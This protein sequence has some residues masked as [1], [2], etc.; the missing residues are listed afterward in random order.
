MIP[1]SQR[2]RHPTS[3]GRPARVRFQS[4]K[5][6][7][8]QASANVYRH[9]KQKLLTSNSAA[10]EERVHHAA[11]ELSSSSNKQ[12]D[13]ESSA[14]RRPTE[15][16]D[17]EAAG[18]ELS[19][20][21]DAV[22]SDLCETTGGTSKRFQSSAFAD[23]L[24]IV[25]DRNPSEIFVKFHRQV[26]PLVRSLPEL[27]H[28]ASQVVDLILSSLLT[29]HC[30]TREEEAA[31]A[32][33]V[34]DVQKQDSNEPMA[35]VP[36]PGI[37]YYS[38]NLATN[39]LLHL[40]AVFARDVR[41]EIHPYLHTRILPRLVTDL[42]R[43]PPIPVP[44]SLPLETVETVF[45]T[46]AYVFKYDATPLLAEVKGSNGDGTASSSSKDSSLPCLELLRQYYGGTLA[47]RNPLVRRLAGETFA[48]VIRR[49]PTDKAQSKH[50]K[51][52]VRS[53]MSVA[54]QGEEGQQVQRQK[55]PVPEFSTSIVP[56]S[57]RLQ[58][59]AADG[60]AGLLWEVARGV[61]G[62]FHSRG[63]NV[64]LSSLLDCMQSASRRDRA[65]LWVVAE[66]T[67]GFLHRALPHLD[68]APAS[69]LM[70]SLVDSTLTMANSIESMSGD[71]ERDDSLT[72]LVQA[73]HQGA[74]FRRGFVLQT[75]PQLQ[76]HF[77][78]LLNTVLA[79]ELFSRLSSACQLALIKLI[80]CVWGAVPESQ[81]FADS[82]C[83]HLRRLLKL[84]NN[85]NEDALSPLD[86][87]T[88]SSLAAILTTELLMRLPVERAMS[89]VGS[90][91]ISAVGSLAKC[92]SSLDDAL[93]LMHSIVLS[94]RAFRPDGQDSD[95][96]FDHSCARYCSISESDRDAIV[97][98][99]MV[100][101]DLGDGTMLDRLAEVVPCLTF[102]I[103]IKRTKD[104]PSQELSKW[105]GKVMEWL[106]G[107]AEFIL[108]S[109]G[110]SGT[111]ELSTKFS[112]ALSLIL[113]SLASL[114]HAFDAD[115]CG[116][117]ARSRQVLRRVRIVSE[118]HMM[119]KTSSH[120][121]MR[122]VAAVFQ[123]LSQDKLKL[124][125]D[126]NLIFEALVPNLSRSNHFLRLHTLVIL[127][128]LPERP[129]VTD[130]SD[131]DWTGDLDEDPSARPFFPEVR[132]GPSGMSDVPKLLLKIESI[133]P[134]LDEERAII[135]QI[136]VVEI[137][138]KTGKLPAAYAE[139]AAA[140]M[141]GVLHCKF[142][143]LWP[144]AI[145]AIVSLTAA[146][147]DVVRPLLLQVLVAVVD[148]TPG[149]AST[150]LSGT[151]K[152]DDVSHLDCRVAWEVRG[153]PGL[154]LDDLE[155]AKEVGRVSWH[156]STDA[157]TIFEYCWEVIEK[158]PRIMTTQSQRFVDL[159]LRFIFHQHL[160]G[161]VDDPDARELQPHLETVTWEA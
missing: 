56:R 94:T 29:E 155:Q 144:A 89:Q 70:Q 114:L 104:A 21:I 100:D 122:S 19:Q 43:P 157:V 51:R 152:L 10:Q 106:L 69:K 81:Q 24:D 107:L 74:A 46:M 133:T 3:D 149:D 66:V 22:E 48:P 27:L 25:L 80:C 52:V 96:F 49:L 87:T 117:T 86:A 159:F 28:H 130:H 11:V 55:N 34:Q 53:L 126:S 120:W 85:T 127:A 113:E 39:D 4:N 64:V 5:K 67:T 119:V 77:L 82:I 103:L 12:K 41:Q 101:Y 84:S 9:V 38:P 154:F 141:L 76:R 75:Q 143:P 73:L 95:C 13:A 98:S 83:N 61:K 140:Q 139:A 1:V 93:P 91:L 145:R 134:S 160:R 123:V 60:I 128:S 92:T 54:A 105:G 135:S 62:Q 109:D 78:Q 151:G 115:E 90:L 18:S 40:L 146:H 132:T 124:D 57:R 129:F 31:A 44:T 153:D 138:G 42:L 148:V 47:H 63:E 6:R 112:V 79:P 36:P 59:D 161:D 110:Y 136:G 35:N 23:E 32:E 20:G 99:W 116:G 7:S 15:R 58:V 2:D 16:M 8:Q 111:D 137:L 118:K 72:C 97:R 68:A 88:V 108:A 102:V 131:I 33:E 158:A 26:W 156:E 50:L 121:A 30:Y 71:N 37:A 65:A 45:R 150:Q 142:A 147:E 125:M 17:D 14:T